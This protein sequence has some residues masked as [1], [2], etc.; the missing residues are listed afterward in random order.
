MTFACPS[1]KIWKLE[2]DNGLS[3]SLLMKI[4]IFVWAL[5][6]EYSY[7]NSTKSAVGKLYVHWTVNNYFSFLFLLFYGGLGWIVEMCCLWLFS[8]FIFEWNGKKSLLTKQSNVDI[9]S[10]LVYPSVVKLAYFHIFIYL[11]QPCNYFK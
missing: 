9:I 5:W 11:T 8:H 4:W 1:F 7:K 3:L 6:F 10:C 2:N